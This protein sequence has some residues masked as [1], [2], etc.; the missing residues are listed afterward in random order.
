MIITYAALNDDPEGEERYEMEIVG[1]WPLQGHWFPFLAAS[2]A[3][4]YVTR[5]KGGREWPSGEPREFALFGPDGEALVV[6]L[7]YMELRRVY[8]GVLKK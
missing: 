8:S 4:A 7:V 1:P 6:F 3:K 2:C 5:Q